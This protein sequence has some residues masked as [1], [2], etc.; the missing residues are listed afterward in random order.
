MYENY[1]VYE[2]TILVDVIKIILN[3]SKRTVLVESKNKKIIGTISEG[4]I[5]R[6]MLQKKNYNSYASKIMNKSFK[7]LIDREDLEMAKSF[8]IKYNVSI[9]P[10][11][12]KNFRLKKI[13]TLKSIL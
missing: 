3:N 10:V 7:Y 13:I 8:F 11:L 6:S 4:D 2:N 1:L 9:I 12:T 5:L